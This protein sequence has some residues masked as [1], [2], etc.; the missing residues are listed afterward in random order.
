MVTLID[1]DLYPDVYPDNS[2]AV[3]LSTVYACGVMAWMANV[4][5]HDA[6]LL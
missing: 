3:K 2:E 1:L 6:L 5:V 4:P